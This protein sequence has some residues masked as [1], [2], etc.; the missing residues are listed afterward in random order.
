[1]YKRRNPHKARRRREREGRS[2]GDVGEKK[3]AW[4]KKKDGERG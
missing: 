2:L 4:D 3:E 1:M